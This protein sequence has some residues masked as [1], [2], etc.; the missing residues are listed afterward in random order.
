MSR[1]AFPAQILRL[2]IRETDMAI[3]RLRINWH[4]AAGE[5]E[6]GMDQT[7][8]EAGKMLTTASLDDKQLSKQQRR[9]RV[10]EF[11]RQKDL[12]RA[13]AK[14][15]AEGKAEG[16]NE[17]VLCPASRHNQFNFI[18]RKLLRNDIRET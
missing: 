8:G 6:A 9:E 1:S 7:A 11:K 4:C 15:Q 13:K 5:T 14:E 2:Q 10:E 17:E 3:H 12:R 18:S 16:Q